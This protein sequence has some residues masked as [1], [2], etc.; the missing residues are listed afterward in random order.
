MAFTPSFRLHLIFLL[1]IHVFVF[2]EGSESWTFSDYVVGYLLIP[3]DSYPC[4]NAC[5]MYR[6]NT[7]T[8]ILYSRVVGDRAQANDTS[9]VTNSGCDIVSL[10]VLCQRFRRWKTLW[11]QAIKALVFKVTTPPFHFSTS[12]LMQPRA[13]R[14]RFGIMH[15][16]NFF[17]VVPPPPTVLNVVTMISKSGQDQPGVIRIPAF[18]PLRDTFSLAR[19]V[20]SR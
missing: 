4:V 10:S 9:I 12:V 2:L 3:T 11:D 1:K 20:Q 13:S 19:F 6:C 8:I 7:R 16:T 14:M 5:L 15:L 18:I 17:C